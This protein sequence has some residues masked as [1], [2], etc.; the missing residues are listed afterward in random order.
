[1]VPGTLFLPIGLLLFGWGAEKR[2]HW[3]M[4]DV[5]LALMYVPLYPHTDIL[6]TESCL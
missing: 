4:A 1:M 2:I 3:I 6:V 5:G